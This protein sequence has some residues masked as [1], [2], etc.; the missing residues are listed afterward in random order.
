MNSPLPLTVH[1]DSSEGSHVHQQILVIPGAGHCCPGRQEQ[2]SHPLSPVQAN[3]CAQGFIRC[4]FSGGAGGVGLSC[5]ILPIS[6]PYFLTRCHTLHV[7]VHRHHIQYLTHHT[8]TSLCH[9]VLPP[10]TS[11]SCHHIP[12]PHVTTYLHLMSTYL[13]LMSPHTSTSCHHI[14]PP[15]VTTYLHPP[16]HTTPTWA[17]VATALH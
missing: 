6:L 11:T 14:P 3:T 12:P 13:H 9:H 16:P 15:H 5:S 2:G 4:S 10:H 1:R 7:H 17:Q 8:H